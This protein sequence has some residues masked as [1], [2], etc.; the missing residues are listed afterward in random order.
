MKCQIVE[1]QVGVW[2]SQ[3]SHSPME[4]SRMETGLTARRAR[5]QVPR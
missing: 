1:L 2:L 4:S 3:S 5:L